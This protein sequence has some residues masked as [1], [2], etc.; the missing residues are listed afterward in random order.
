M[1]PH[2]WGWIVI[3]VT[4]ICGAATIFLAYNIPKRR[5]R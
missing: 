1:T 4:V 5:S 2:L 3:W